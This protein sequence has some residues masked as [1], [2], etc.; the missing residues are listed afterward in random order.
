VVVAVTKVRVGAGVLVL[1]VACSPAAPA[2]RVSAEPILDI[3]RIAF[4]GGGIVESETRF[5][6]VAP[7]VG[8]KTHITVRARSETPAGFPPVGAY[9]DQYESDLA[10]E[11]VAIEASATTEV[12]VT[13]LR[14]VYITGNG[15]LP[16]AV[17]GKSYLVGVKPPY[18]RDENGA[19]A[20]PEQAERVLDV[21]PDPGTRS[22]I[23]E[24][25]PD[26]PLAIGDRRDDLA[27]AVLHVM[28]PRAWTP[29]RAVATLARIENGH[30]IF[31]V[32]LAAS[33]ASSGKM[34]V[35]GDVSIH[36]SGA[37]LESISLSGTYGS[38]GK[39]SY[40][41]RIADM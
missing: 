34:D 12:R 17:D 25:L 14:N 8:Q 23:D 3:P 16:T 28:H 19:A 35:T 6:R 5:S 32:S 1:A 15:E 26:G 36:L 33:S 37:S 21:F 29:E 27:R 39:F 11:V 40:S 30:A 18:V 41:R 10:V 2:P 7:R 22:R 4:D 9:V 38:D 31:S 24:A 20:P 13:F